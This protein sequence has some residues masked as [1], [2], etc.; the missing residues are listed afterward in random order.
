MAPNP[1][2][3]APQACWINEPMLLNA[4]SVLIY[5]GLIGK[6][7]PKGRIGLTI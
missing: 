3:E 1:K 5:T 7:D 2:S 6:I 4:N